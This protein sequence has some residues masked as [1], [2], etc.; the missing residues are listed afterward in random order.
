M[1]ERL[2]AAKLNVAAASRFWYNL[3]NGNLGFVGQRQR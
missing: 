2:A 1:W 3:F